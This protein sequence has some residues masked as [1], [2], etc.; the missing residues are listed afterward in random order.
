[1]RLRPRLKRRRYVGAA[2]LRID[3]AGDYVFNGSTS[4]SWALPKIEQGSWN[5][6]DSDIAVK[7]IGTGVLTLTRQGADNY[8]D[9]GT[10]SVTT[11]TLYR[12][13]AV[14]LRPD[15]TYFQVFAKASMSGVTKSI[16][17]AVS[18]SS[19]NTGTTLA[20]VT[21]MSWPLSIS[22]EACAKFV[23]NLGAALSTT[24][25]KIAVTAPSGITTISIN[26]T[27]FG[28]NGTTFTRRSTTAGSGGAITFTA[29]ELTGVSNGRLEIELYAKNS[30]TL[31]TLQLQAAQETSSA[32]PLVFGVGSITRFNRIA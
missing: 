19:A 29:A 7:N 18:L 31:G 11:L 6:D 15:G 13:D 16:T 14:I 20:D 21:N 3:A 24:G 23:L 9:T 17:T 26:A 4:Q 10:A 27:L 8:F 30:T 12:G 28:D 1:M 5:Y 22:E 2:Q 25:C 32:T